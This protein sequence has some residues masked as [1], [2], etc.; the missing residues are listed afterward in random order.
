VGDYYAARAAD[1]D[2]WLGGMQR[3]QAKVDEYV[4]TVS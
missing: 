2:R 4:G 3:L 1:T